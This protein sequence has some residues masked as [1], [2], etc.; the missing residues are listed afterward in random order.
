[1]PPVEVQHQVDGQAVTETLHGLS[2]ATERLRQQDPELVYG[3]GPKNFLPLGL[4]FSFFVMWTPIAAGQPSGMVRLMSFKDTPSLRRALLLVG[5][6]YVLTYLSLLVIFVCARA[7]FP[8]QYLGEMGSEGQPDSIMPIMTRHVAHPLVA[9]L[10]LA[11]PYAAIMSTVAAFLLIISSGLVRDLYQRTVNP[12]VSDRTMKRL[13]YLITAVVG[14]VVMLG[15]L[16]PPRFLQY[17]I[18]FTGTGQGCSF[19]VPMALGLYWKRATRQGML[20]A[21]LGGFAVVLTLYALGWL[22]SG[23]QAALRDYQRQSEQAAQAGEPGPPPPAA[24]WL[25]ENFRG[26][27]G[28]GEKRLDAFAPLYLGGLDPLVWGLLVSL[29]LG[30]GVSLATRPDPELVAKYFPD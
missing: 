12:R 7:I 14:V 23:S 2:A 18:V 3:P 10:L 24:R 4:A 17:I 27:P 26:I 29:V 25:Q 8:T 9:G 6:Y 21:M 28:W 16:N 11:A 5:A 30:V 1:V 22:D 13:S 15:A 20:A 19:L